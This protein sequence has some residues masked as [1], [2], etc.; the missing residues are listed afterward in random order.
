MVMNEGVIQQIGTPVDIY[1]E[2]KNIFVAKFIGE[3]NILP[4]TMLGD[5]KV[6]FHGREFTCVDAGFG[7]NTPVDVVVRPEDIDLYEESRSSLTGVVKS[8]LFMG[9]HYEFRV[10]TGDF[11]WTVHSTDYIE[12]GSRVSLT[13][14]PDA[15]HIMHKSVNPDEL[16]MPTEDERFEAALAEEEAEA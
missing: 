8:V 6:R 16:E 10:D 9:V 15:I 14:L 11:V 5:Y 7:S 12:P 1:N 13:I 4:G 3:S 2:P